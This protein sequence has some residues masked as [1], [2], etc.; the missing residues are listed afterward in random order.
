MDGAD[1]SKQQCGRMAV[2]EARGRSSNT[3][4]SNFLEWW[5]TGAVTA[6]RCTHRTNSKCVWECTVTYTG[7]REIWEESWISQVRAASAL[8]REWVDPLK[9]STSVISGIENPRV[10]INFNET[11][12]RLLWKHHRPIKHTCQQWTT[13]RL[14]RLFIFRLVLRSTQQSITVWFYF[15]FTF[16]KQTMLENATSVTQRVVHPL[17]TDG[18][19][20]ESILINKSFA[21]RR[22]NG[23]MCC[24]NNASSCTEH[25]RRSTVHYND[26]F[27]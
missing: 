10:L 12:W 8:Q 20:V 17:E 16:Q 6:L 27:F 11:R 7:C 22:R 25:C 2:W 4:T 9:L 21:F 18:C 5:M 13:G 14:E 26:I 1:C 3:S 23:T 19:K 15:F 24:Q